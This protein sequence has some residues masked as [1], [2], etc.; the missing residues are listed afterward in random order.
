ME[1]SP[2]YEFLINK[3]RTIS[4]YIEYIWGEACLDEIEYYNRCQ[5]GV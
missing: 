4:Y 3:Q 5:D 1:Y 2:Y